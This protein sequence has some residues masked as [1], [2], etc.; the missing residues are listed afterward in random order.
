GQALEQIMAGRVEAA[1]QRQ[2]Q[3]R[4]AIRGVGDDYHPFD[5]SCGAPC[6]ADAVRQRLTARFAAID[7]LAAEAGLAT[8]ARQRIDKARRVE[9]QAALEREAARCAELFQ[10]SS[11]CVEGR[12]GQLSLRH[13]YLHQ[14]R[15]RKLKVL[16]TLHNYLIRR[17]D[18]TTAAERFFG[19]KPGDLFE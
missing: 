7:R 1:E 2:E 3:M 10:R 14:L 9:S 12:N 18:G 13:H 16:T 19:A 6:D 8:P 11:S 17:P 15:P 4:Q 5:L